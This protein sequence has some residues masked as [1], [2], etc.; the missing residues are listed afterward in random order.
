MPDDIFTDG[1]PST[2]KSAKAA[3][4]TKVETTAALDD[5]D[6]MPATITS[7][8]AQ[9]V[10]TPIVKSASI[11]G[12]CIDQIEWYD[13]VQLLTK[14]RYGRDHDDVGSN[15][16][17]MTEL[18]VWRFDLLLAMARGELSGPKVHDTGRGMMAFAGHD[19]AFRLRKRF[20]VPKQGFWGKT[21]AW[22]PDGRV[23][24]PFKGG[25]W[26]CDLKSV[27]VYSGLRQRPPEKTYVM[28]TDRPWESVSK[29][30]SHHPGDAADLVAVAYN[31][32]ASLAVACGAKG[33]IMC[34]KRFDANAMQL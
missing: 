26:L 25:L 22:S 17:E 2:S 11:Q 12:D 5:D 13:D 23:A 18:M 19:H 32:D 34:W 20:V 7:R 29:A 30:A 24:V 3:K 4:S 15:C 27:P 16:G 33:Q 8:R 6:S 10:H 28:P 1:I 21:M 14:A 9:Q 31:S